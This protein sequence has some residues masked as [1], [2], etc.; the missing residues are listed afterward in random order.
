M[1]LQPLPRLSFNKQLIWL[2]QASFC[3]SAWCAQRPG[4]TR[5]RTEHPYHT[6]QVAE[7]R[8][9]AVHASKPS[10]EQTIPHY[11]PKHFAKGIGFGKKNPGLSLTW[12]GTSP[13]PMSAWGSAHVGIV[14]FQRNITPVN[15]IKAGAGCHKQFSGCQETRPFLTLL[16]TERV[17]DPSGHNICNNSSNLGHRPSI[18]KQSLCFSYFSSWLPQTIVRQ[19]H[20]FIFWPDHPHVFN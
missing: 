2:A 7:E 12:A 6:V 15:A 18:S 8:Q 3:K 17:T 11:H 1:E 13:L 4:T 5:V 20:D 14:L 19:N 10:L 9:A 16:Q